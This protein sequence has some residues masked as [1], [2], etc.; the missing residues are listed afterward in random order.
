MKATVESGKASAWR[1]LIL[2]GLLAFIAAMAF[3]AFF[4]IMD[5]GPL[6]PGPETQT[7]ALILT[8]KEMLATYREDNGAYPDSPENYLLVKSMSGQNPSKKNYYSFSDQSFLNANKEIVD[9]WGTPLRFDFKGKDDVLII[10]AGPDKIFG[11]AD[12]IT[13]DIKGQ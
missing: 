12:D 9:S 7:T 8:L 11:T 13:G 3:L 1:S 10:S 4:V 5:K 6:P 2:W